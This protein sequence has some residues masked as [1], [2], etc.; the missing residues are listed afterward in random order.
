M[1]EIWQDVKITYKHTY[2]YRSWAFITV[3]LDQLKY[4]MSKKSLIILSNILL[5]AFSNLVEYQQLQLN[6]NSSKLYCRFAAQ[7]DMI[8][9]DM[10]KVTREKAKRKQVLIWIHQVY[11]EYQYIPS[12]FPDFQTN[13]RKMREWCNY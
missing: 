2:S 4:Q 3:S 12:N 13:L 7:F 6:Y 1:S 5:H 9:S 8:F 11:V 10:S